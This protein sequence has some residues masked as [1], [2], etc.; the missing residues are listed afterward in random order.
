MSKS[1]ALGKHTD[2]SITVDPHEVLVRSLRLTLEVLNWLNATKVFM[3][4]EPTMRQGAWRYGASQKV[5]EMTR[6]YAV[7]IRYQA[8]PGELEKWANEDGAVVLKTAL[9]ALG[10]LF[11]EGR[12]Q[13]ITPDLEA[14]A[15]RYGI[16]S[17]E[18][19]D[20]FQL[21]LDHSIE[22]V[23]KE[24]KAGIKRQDPPPDWFV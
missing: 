17:Q 2:S 22:K 15:L 5:D 20:L 3:P 6:L 1:N 16:E 23:E 9:S 13:P 8:N 18:L 7:M 21:V 19:G 14:A 4:T 10:I 11:I 24:I 12:F